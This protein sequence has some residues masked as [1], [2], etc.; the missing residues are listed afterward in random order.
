MTATAKPGLTELARNMSSNVYRAAYEDGISLTE[1]LEREY[2]D[3]DS[4][5]DAFERLLKES[6]IRTNPIPEKG[7]W[8]NPFSD[9]L[10]DEASRALFPEWAARQWRSVSML[11]SRSIYGTGDDILNSIPR[12]YADALK[13]RWDKRIAPAIPSNML[14]AITTPIRGT[15][16]RS[17]YL[18]NDATNQRKTRVNP[19]TDIP[20]A[21]LVG[22]QHEI[23]LHKYG[24][25]LEWTYEAERNVRIDKMAMHIQQMAVQSEV[26]K[27]GTIIDVIVNGD[28][29]NNAAIVHTLTS[30]DSTTTANNLTLIAWLAFK[31]KFAN[32]YMVQNVLAREN[33][34]LKL[35]TLSVGSANVPLVM[36]QAASGFGFFKPINP[37]LSDTPGLGWTDDA[38]ASTIVASDS[39]VAIEHVT[40]IGADISEIDRF[41]KNQTKVLTM[42]EVDGYGVNDKNANHVLDLTQ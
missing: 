24:R 18:Q 5:L 3:K 30:L 31:M 34:A 7:I 39:R 6:G 16:Y 41:V 15:A 13:A 2:P 21:K 32:P 4:R 26:D 35:L 28:G 8:A 38:P 42:T 37:G 14:V 12:P 22:S 27:V 10:K 36:I 25:A 1:Y 29:N 40:E 19:G 17:F 11:N 33:V 9:F 20:T 23:Q